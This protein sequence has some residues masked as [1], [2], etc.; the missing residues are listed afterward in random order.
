M[1]FKQEGNTK[2]FT[3][4]CNTS[5]KRFVTHQNVYIQVDLCSPDLYVPSDPGSDY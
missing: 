5:K 3:F 4:F 2:T 1:F